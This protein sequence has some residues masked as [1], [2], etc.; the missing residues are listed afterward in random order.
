M[1]VNLHRPVTLAAVAVFNISIQV[2]MPYLILYYN[3]SLGMDNYVLIFAPAIILA[4]AFTAFYGKVY[5]RKGFATAVIPTVVLL[6]SGYVLL[7]L[8]K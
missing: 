3:V 2:F 4:A 5:D 8:R 7:Y 6:M 1:R